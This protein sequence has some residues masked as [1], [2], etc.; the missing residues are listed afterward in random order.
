[1]WRGTRGCAF[2]RRRCHRGKK[3]TTRGGGG[4][5]GKRSGKGVR[6]T[7]DSHRN[8]LVMGTEEIIPEKRS[9]SD[10]GGGT[11]PSVAVRSKRLPLLGKNRKKGRR[12][13]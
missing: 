6:P 7:L 5:K 9:L 4:A 12:E 1:V 13:K 2:P 10:P 8:V 3:K 11:G